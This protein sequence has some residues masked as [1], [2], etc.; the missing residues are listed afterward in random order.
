MSN[1]LSPLAHAVPYL[2]SLGVALPLL[3]DGKP[4]CFPP[5]L[6]TLDLSVWARPNKASMAALLAAIGQLQ[7][8]HALRLHVQRAEVCLAP[9]Q[10]LPQLRDLKLR[11]PFPPN[12]GQFAADL[13]ALRCLHRLHIDAHASA[14]SDSIRVAFLHALLGD[15]SEEEMRMLQ[16]RDFT[17]DGFRFN[18]ELT[19]L[20]LR[21]P[22]LGCVKARLPA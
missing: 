17:F 6:R 19:P 9:L 16:W 3:S 11:L 22:L 5:R 13:R 7:Q 10:Q 12:L 15:G 8:L 21:L 1:Q 2:Q 18:D 20:L 4:L 14:D